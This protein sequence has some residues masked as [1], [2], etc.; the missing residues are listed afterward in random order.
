ML[1]SRPDGNRGRWQGNGVSSSS[2]S[3]SS[4]GGRWQDKTYRGG[5]TI[6]NNCNGCADHRSNEI[7]NISKNDGNG[8]NNRSSQ[9]TMTLAQQQ[10]HLRSAA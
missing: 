10:Q 3:S 6:R 5:E 2:S 8:S 9:I 4:N 7:S 1:R